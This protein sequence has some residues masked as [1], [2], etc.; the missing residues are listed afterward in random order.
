MK[1]YYLYVV[2]RFRSV[3]NR[4]EKDGHQNVYDRHGVYPILVF[5]MSGPVK[6]NSR[7][8][9]VQ[10]YTTVD[11]EHCICKRLIASVVIVIVNVSRTRV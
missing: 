7:V 5:V 9:A 2:K 10:V 6:R 3:N 1:T 11:G 8:D 4:R